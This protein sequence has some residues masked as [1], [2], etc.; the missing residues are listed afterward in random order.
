MS[1]LGW[2]DLMLGRSGGQQELPVSLSDT[3]RFPVTLN[4]ERAVVDEVIPLLEETLVVCERF[5]RSEV[6]L[7]C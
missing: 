7:G 6:R 5:E 4:A 1:A 2:W 3:G